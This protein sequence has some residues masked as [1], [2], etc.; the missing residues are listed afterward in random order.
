M[1]PG[2]FVRE[3]PL[4]TR[5]TVT[6][7][8]RV[9]T[10]TERLRALLGT[11][12]YTNTC[13]LVADVAV[14]S[15]LG[16]AFWVLVA[17]LYSPAQVGIAS[18]TVA[19]V[20]L[21]ARLSHLGFGYGLIRFLP[22]AR[23]RASTLINSCLTIA[24]LTS[25]VAALIFLSGLNLWSPA[26]LYIRHPGLSVFFVFL[27]VAY[28]LFLLLDQT[29]I[30]QRRGEFVLFKN[31]AAGAAK[32]A[33]AIALA[34]LLKTFGIFVSWG[35]A[36]FVALAV[37]LF[38]FLPRLQHRN[39]SIPAVSKEL[40]NDMLHFSLGNYIAE[41]LWFAPLALFPLMVINTLGAETNAYFYIPWVIAQMLF[42]I[43]IAIAYSLFA[44]GSNDEHLLLSNTLKSLKLC[45][46]I[47]VPAGV[48]L[49]ALSDKL[50]LLFGSSYS[51]S[52]TTLL[53]ILALSV[54]P[55]GINYIGLS[56][57]RVK[58]N[59]RGVIL[60][61]ASI[62]GLALGSGYILMT[63]AG[64]IGIGVAWIATQ[65]LVAVVVVLFLFYTFYRSK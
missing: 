39:I 30:A 22:G 48:A 28:S 7:A 41:L 34:S 3:V 54:I 1:F 27:T 58:K 57:M 4:F 46:L 37:A 49:F 35:L 40:V 21:L 18:A 61:S 59:T 53:R 14:V 43:P 64:L 56:V 6:Q 11:S 32:I 65:T 29:F 45:L 25:L 55:V 13:Y 17:R 9:I 47:L 20:V 10:S 63:G 15:M 60:V 62:A 2:T 33:A 8:V 44:E 24:G 42:A 26:L 50:L 16:F 23:E 36:I 52:N 5:D 31:A 12:L 38:W 51:E 19:A